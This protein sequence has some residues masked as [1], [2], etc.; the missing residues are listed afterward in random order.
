M[1]YNIH[2]TL[3]DEWRDSEKNP[4]TSDLLEEVSRI[5]HDTVSG[6]NSK[7]GEVI[8]QCFEDSFYWPS[9]NSDN[10]CMFHLIGG[11]LI[12]KYHDKNQIEIAKDLASY[13]GAKVQG[14]D[15]EV[16]EYQST[17]PAIDKFKLI[18]RVIEKL[19][20]IS[21]VIICIGSFSVYLYIKLKS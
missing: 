16:Y 11:R 14:D 20:M 17:K 12:F 7:T 18:S 2:I 21:L 6:V 15:G 5:S 19:S 1:G 13:L 4:I 3:A 10:K 8:E 9:E